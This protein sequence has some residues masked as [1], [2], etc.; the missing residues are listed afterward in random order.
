MPFDAAASGL[1]YGVE[2]T[3]NKRFGDEDAWERIFINPN[4]DTVMDGFNIDLRGFIK[5]VTPGTTDPVTGTTG[6]P[7]ITYGYGNITNIDVL[8]IT[9]TQKA[10]DLFTEPDRLFVDTTITAAPSVGILDDSYY[11]WDKVFDQSRVRYIEGLDCETPL[12]DGADV[13]QESLTLLPTTPLDLTVDPP[14]YPMD[15]F[16][17]VRPDT[18]PYVILTFTATFSG[19]IEFLPFSETVTWYQEVWQ[20]AYDWGAYI[21]NALGNYTYFVAGGDTS[22]LRQFPEGYPAVNPN[23][24]EYEE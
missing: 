14:I 22:D 3:I 11:Q 13:E 19:T 15:I 18:R 16:T 1:D 2:W 20:K 5:N 21:G 7:T 9:C 23:A 8:T 24:P 12:I 4:S 10:G 17:S 6:P